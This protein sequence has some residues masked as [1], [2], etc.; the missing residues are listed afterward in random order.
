MDLKFQN[1]SNS[2][3]KFEWKL[4][5]RFFQDMP[6]R[7]PGG[8]GTSKLEIEGVPP[9]AVENLLEYCYKDR[10]W[11]S[12]LH[13]VPYIVDVFRFDRSDFENGYSR[14]LLWRLWHI[15]KVLQMNHLFELCSEVCSHLWQQFIRR[16]RFHVAW[17]N[18]CKFKALN[19]TLS[20]KVLNILR[21][22]Y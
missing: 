11:F 14:N 3:S 12:L 21:H 17:N 18:L 13:M 22:L 1:V 8:S 9:I 15:S 16:N 4:S 20:F 2:Q 7:A 19:L 6:P 10:Y 5:D